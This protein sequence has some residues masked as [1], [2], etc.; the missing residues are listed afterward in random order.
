M[1]DNRPHEH[2]GR[3]VSQIIWPYAPDG[4]FERIQSHNGVQLRF[5]SEYLGDHS[6]HWILELSGGIERR[7]HNTRFIE[8]I[9]WIE[10]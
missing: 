8:T 9:I 6:E 1:N 2:H 10:D 5:H 4:S 3:D 7:R